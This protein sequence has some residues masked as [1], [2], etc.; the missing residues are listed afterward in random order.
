MKRSRVL[1]RMFACLVVSLSLALPAFGLPRGLIEEE[2]DS[3]SQSAP[4][5]T[6][7][8]TW[9]QSTARSVAQK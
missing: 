2:V 7:V 6:W 8:K 1:P 3:S 5:A 4:D 9:S